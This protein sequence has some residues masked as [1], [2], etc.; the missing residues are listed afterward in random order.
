MLQAPAGSTSTPAGPKPVDTYD[1]H[2]HSDSGGIASEFA[3]CS[4]ISATDVGRRFAFFVGPSC[5]VALTR[6]LQRS[7]P[8]TLLE[9]CASG[10]STTEESNII[11]S[12]THASSSRESLTLPKMRGGLES[13]PST[14]IYKYAWRALG[15]IMHG[16]SSGVLRSTY[17]FPSVRKTSCP[18]A[19]TLARN[20]RRFRLKCLGLLLSRLARWS[21]IRQPATCTKTV[22]ALP[23][24]LANR[25]PR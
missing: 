17:G 22:T 13:S 23:A 9:K 19:S 16:I 14:A 4:G 21:G 5:D 10:G 12:Q 24:R 25:Q 3:K 11:V 8:A 2:H 6:A 20:A 18:F 7:M 15:G 1:P